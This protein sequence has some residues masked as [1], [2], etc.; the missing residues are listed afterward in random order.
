MFR[1]RPF[2]YCLLAVALALPARATL[3]WIPGEGWSD[4]SS[5]TDA[6][7]SSS[8]DQLELA[9]KAEAEGRRDDALKAYK[10]LLRRWPLSFF[11]PEAQFRVG[12]LLEDEADFASAFK[13]FQIMVQKYPSSDYFEQ[14]LGE[15]YRIANLYL[16]GEPQ[17]IWKI[18]VGPS[19]DHTVE[20][21]QQVIKNA[22]YGT[23]AAQCQFNIGLAREQQRRYTDA[24]DAYQLVIDNYP[25][26]SVAANAQYQIGYAWM[27]ASTSGDY[28]MGAAKKAVDAFQ[29]FLVRYPDSDK[30]VQAQE[31][32]QK[33]GQHQTQGAFA[34][35]K[36]YETQHQPRAAF[37]YYNE[38]IREDPN[39]P[40]AQL[41]KKRIQELKPVLDALPGGVGPDGTPL[42]AQAQNTTSSS[43]APATD[44]GPSTSS[45]NTEPPD[46]A[47]GAG[48]LPTD[49]NA[50]VTSSS[51]GATA[52][53]AASTPGGNG[54]NSPANTSAGTSGASDAAP[55][56]AA[57][58]SEALDHTPLPQ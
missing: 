24:V 34:V 49:P 6:T 48:T 27:R 22:P 2:L 33:L 56:D 51:P 15:Q 55:A 39:G 10:A 43:S 19:M 5:G 41:A 13:A 38:V 45:P 57:A 14:A 46:T 16:A 52:A 32:I 47:P 28:D 9:H 37:I 44:P 20:L 53:G 18:P 35:A 3:T 23:Y 11:A 58:S 12:K 29:D 1:P 36:F 21:Y 8:R 7:A 17:R 40:Q 31:N 25:M 42:V 30:A 50:P 54:S 4:D 26:S